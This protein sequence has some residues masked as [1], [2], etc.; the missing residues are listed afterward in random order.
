MSGQL[1][2]YSQAD[3][4]EQNSRKVLIFIIISILIFFN[5]LL[6]WQFF[7]K[8]SH[9]EEVSKSLESTTA[10]RDALSAELQRV[11]AEFEKVN[12]ENSSLQS[13]LLSK[14]EEIKSKMAQIRRMIESGDAAQLKIAREEL[15]RLKSMNQVY[16][17]DLDSLKSYNSTL[18]S[19]NE[20]LSTSLNQERDRINSLTQENSLLSNKV[21]VASVLKTT[22]FK[23][24]GIRYKSSG[25]EIETM[26]ASSAQKI[27]T[28]FTILENTVANSGNKDI[29]MRVMSPDGVVM[30]AS[31]ETFMVNGQASLYTTKESFEYDNK[32]M[33]LCVYWEKGSAY[34]AG[35]YTIEIY[36]EGNLIASSVID[37]K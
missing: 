4:R 3:K 6:L 35:K 7:D 11:K 19:Q 31:S 29:Y 26:K 20:T 37:L 14:D 13:L 33:N 27:K 22:A 15:E 17:Q 2:D 28:C 32:E 16:V 18:A 21:A 1:N 8:K 34:A 12:Q 30:T 36:C 25:R 10:E 9:L 23:A 5:G 24:T